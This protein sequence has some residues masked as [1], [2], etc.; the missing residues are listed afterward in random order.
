MFGGMLW[1]SYVVD[2]LMCDLVILLH[3]FFRTKEEIT[4]LKNGEILSQERI[5]AA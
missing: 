4:I 2:R 1:V 3:F 5:F